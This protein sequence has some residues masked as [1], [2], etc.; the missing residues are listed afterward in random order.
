MFW[1]VHMESLETVAHLRAGTLNKEANLGVPMLWTPAQT[2]SWHASESLE[3]LLKL[4]IVE[5]HA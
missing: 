4:Q 3:G 2:G 1:L 5:S